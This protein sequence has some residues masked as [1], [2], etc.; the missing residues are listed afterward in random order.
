V[1]SIYNSQSKYKLYFSVITGISN[2]SAVIFA[3]ISDAKLG[4]VKTILFG[5]II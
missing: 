3:A 5:K 4:R 2:I 1:N